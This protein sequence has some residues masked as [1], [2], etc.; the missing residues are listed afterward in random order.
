[1]KPLLSTL[2]LQD[3]NIIAFHNKYYE[4]LR[5]KFLKELVGY[6]IWTRALHTINH[7]SWCMHQKFSRAVFSIFYSYGTIFIYIFICRTHTV[8]I[9]RI[10]VKKIW[11][12]MFEGWERTGNGREYYH[13]QVCEYVN[14]NNWLSKKNLFHTVT[15]VTANKTITHTLK[16]HSCIHS[17]TPQSST[18]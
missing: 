4:F 11:A 13:I 1:M 2:R 9:L 14:Y 15:D 8:I 5:T 16:R 3:I 10:H 6:L 17:E 18:Q 12:C 7:F